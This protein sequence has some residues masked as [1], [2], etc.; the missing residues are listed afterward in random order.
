MNRT[1]FGPHLWHIDSTPERFMERWMQSVDALEQ[2]EENPKAANLAADCREFLTSS[3]AAARRHFEADHTQEPELSR[4][5]YE[6]MKEEMLSVV[7]I[8]EERLNLSS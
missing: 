3:A 7:S 8:V 1:G 6:S 5:H 2:I 4:R